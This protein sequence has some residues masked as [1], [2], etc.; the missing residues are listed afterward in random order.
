MK[1]SSWVVVAVVVAERSRGVEGSSLAPQL[2][3]VVV[4]VTW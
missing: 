1:Y 4:A 3:G 2:E